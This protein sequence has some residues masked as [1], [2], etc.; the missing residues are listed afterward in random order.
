MYV[1]ATP[2]GYDILYDFLGALLHNSPVVP[3]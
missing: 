1:V 2:G 3:K